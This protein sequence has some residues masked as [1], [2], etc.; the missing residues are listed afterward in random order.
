MLLYPSQP[1]PGSSLG[2]PST[3]PVPLF[4]PTN[5]MAQGRDNSVLL[6]GSTPILQSAP[7]NDPERSHTTLYPPHSY[8]VSPFT[9]DIA[10]VACFVV[11]AG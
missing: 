8:H 5:T 4:G 11:A 3:V 2:N 9:M 10:V 1:G 6:M 7:T